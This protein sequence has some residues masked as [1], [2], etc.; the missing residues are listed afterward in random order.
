MP[1]FIIHLSAPGPRKYQLAAACLPATAR[2]RGILVE[3]RMPRGMP[4]VPGAATQT[5]GRGQLPLH[6]VFGLMQSLSRDLPRN[7]VSSLSDPIT[8][9]MKPRRLGNSAM[10]FRQSCTPVRSPKPASGLQGANRHEVSFEQNLSWNS[11]W[12]RH[13]WV[14][15][16]CYKC[17]DT[18]SLTL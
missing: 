11:A 16:L 13:R 2:G 15:R 1:L 10:L 4:D 12:P 14:K 5:K 6:F 8:P 7:F 17:Q 18:F 9:T 3:L